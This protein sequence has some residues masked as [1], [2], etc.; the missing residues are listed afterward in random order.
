MRNIKEMKTASQAPNRP[1]NFAEFGGSVANREFFFLAA[2]PQLGTARHP[3]R[4]LSD[5]QTELPH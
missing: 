4:M 3:L 5:V 2:M 1:S